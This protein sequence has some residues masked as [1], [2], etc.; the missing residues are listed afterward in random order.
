M[1]KIA[2]SLMAVL[3]VFTSSAQ[4]SPYVLTRKNTIPTFTVSTSVIA[5]SFL[6]KRYKKPLD[7]QTIMNLDRNDVWKFD[8]NATY[9]WNTRAAHWSDGLMFLSMATPLLFLS[10]KNS[11]SDYGKVATISAE[12]FLVNT[13]MTFLVKELVKR[14]RPFTYN[15]DAPLS[16]K[17]ERDASSSFFSGHT[18][19][20]AAMSFAFAQMHSDYYPDSRVRPFV[21]FSATSLPLAVAILRNKAGKHF[22]T[23]VLVGY[24]VGAATG[25]LIPRIHRVDGFRN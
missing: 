6:L 12:V 18:S 15:A 13:G 1:K 2:V 7:E 21:W 11:R 4:E 5:T 17:M 23:D 22:W 3:L 9:N 25:I 24:A 16:K 19:T 8:R 10:G 20:T 14:K